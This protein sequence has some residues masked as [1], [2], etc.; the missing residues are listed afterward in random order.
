MLSFRC[1]IYPP[2]TCANL[3][4]TCRAFNK[5]RDEFSRTRDTLLSDYRAILVSQ[6]R[7][8]DGVCLCVR[9]SLSQGNFAWDGKRGNS[10]SRG[11]RISFGEL[12]NWSFRDDR[13]V[14]KAMLYPCMARHRSSTTPE[15]IRAAVFLF[16]LNIFFRSF[17]AITSNFSHYSYL[18]DAESVRAAPGSKKSICLKKTHKNK[19]RYYFCRLV[20]VL[21][22][23][24]VDE[25]ADSAFPPW[26]EKNR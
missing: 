19:R 25:F 17:H 23:Q 22:I 3:R 26:R 14:S 2:G 10:L 21:F 18:P 4:L 11:Y 24:R 7:H 13:K 6:T 20:G 5:L 15:T 1:V 16:L 9:A 8:C 12:I